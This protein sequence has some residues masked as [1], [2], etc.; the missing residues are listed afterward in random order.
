MNRLLGSDFDIRQW[1]HRALFNAP[2]SRIEM[3]LEAR[4]PVRVCWS[5]GHRNWLAGQRIHTENSYKW[6]VESFTALLRDAGFGTGGAQ[7]VQAW[8]NPEHPFALVWAAA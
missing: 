3:H 7:T 4:E 2:A 8:V 5:T 1:R 6:T